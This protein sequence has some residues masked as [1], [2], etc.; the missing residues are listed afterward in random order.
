[1]KEKL[2]YGNMGHE[3]IVTEGGKDFSVRNPLAFYHLA[4]ME[5]REDLDLDF[6]VLF[7]KLL[8]FYRSAKFLPFYYQQSRLIKEL[9]IKRSRLVKARA[10]LIKVGILTE[11]NPGNGKK[12]KFILNRDRIIALVPHLYKMPKEESAKVALIN[13]LQI[14]YKY[15]LSKRYLRK[16]HD[17]FMPDEIPELRVSLTGNDKMDIRDGN[18]MDDENNT[19]KKGDV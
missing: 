17:S 9:H 5:Y 15:F 8:V 3:L 4:L 12:I 19:Y 6:I 16:N 7:E 10:L 2:L 18:K 11:V 13:E 1:M 14:F